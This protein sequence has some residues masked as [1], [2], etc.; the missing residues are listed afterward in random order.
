MRCLFTSWWCHRWRARMSDLSCFG[1]TCII[2]GQRIRN[3]E[4][5]SN[6]PIN[7]Y[8]FFTFYRAFYR[9]WFG[10][11]WKIVYTWLTKPS[12]NYKMKQEWKNWLSCRVL[13]QLPPLIVSTSPP[14]TA[15]DSRPGDM[16]TVGAV[17]IPSIITDGFLLGHPAGSLC[18][19]AYTTH[20]LG[21]DLVKPLLRV[22]PSFH[23]PFSIPI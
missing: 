14:L 19:A 10:L 13:P 6:C 20:G 7:S 2:K 12:V 23:S 4:K 5:R 9:K 16:D 18:W 15:H 11:V 3:W 22:L 17:W 21:L 8:L 1:G